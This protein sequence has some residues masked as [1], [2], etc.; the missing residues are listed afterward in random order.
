MTVVGIAVLGDF[1][2]GSDGRHAR[3]LSAESPEIKAS[4]PKGDICTAASLTINPPPPPLPP[5][6]NSLFAL[7]S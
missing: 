4:S 1:F 7:F 2:S 5:S 3:F 6:S